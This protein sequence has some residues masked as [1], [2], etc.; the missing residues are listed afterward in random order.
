MFHGCFFLSISACSSFDCEMGRF[1][2]IDKRILGNIGDNF[3]FV[4]WEYPV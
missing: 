4:A 3:I 2:F 1:F